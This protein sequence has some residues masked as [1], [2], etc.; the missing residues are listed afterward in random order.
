MSRSSGDMQKVEKEEAARLAAELDRCLGEREALRLRLNKVMYTVISVFTLLG[1]L[2]ISVDGRW[3]STTRW[4]ADASKTWDSA[5]WVCRR[6]TRIACPTPRTWTTCPRPCLTRSRTGSSSSLVQSMV[7][8][9]ATRYV[10]TDVYVHTY[11]HLSE[12]SF[13]N[14]YVFV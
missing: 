8:A 5:S 2:I 14:V 7:L 6:T 1:M 13:V 9:V 4:L 10:H 12:A 11:T 3:R